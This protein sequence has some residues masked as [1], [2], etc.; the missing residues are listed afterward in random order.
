M[1]CYIATDCAKEYRQKKCIMAHP[2]VYSVITFIGGTL[3]EY[4]HHSHSGLVHLLLRLH[5]SILV[6]QSQ[7]FNPLLQDPVLMIQTIPTSIKLYQPKL[8]VVHFQWVKPTH[9]DLVS[10]I[11]SQY[12]MCI[13]HS[14]SYLYQIHS[15]Y[16]M[17]G[18][19]L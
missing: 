15:F 11:S 18:Q 7:R 8:Q 14:S 19:L 9:N 3:K 16:G 5:P 17:V 6:V 13:Q 4:L 2:S 1:N 12:H 10:G